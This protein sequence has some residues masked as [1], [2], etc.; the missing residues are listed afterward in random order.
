M[1][2]FAQILAVSSFRTKHRL[3]LGQIWRGFRTEFRRA[4]PCSLKL[5][6]PYDAKFTAEIKKKRVNLSLNPERILKLKAVNSE[7]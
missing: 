4:R 5:K 2:N 1:L 6:W 7:I 3:S